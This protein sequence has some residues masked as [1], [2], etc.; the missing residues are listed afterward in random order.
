MSNLNVKEK[1]FFL[2]VETK[3]RQLNRLL[4]ELSTQSEQMK[5]KLDG[6]RS[7]MNTK[8]KR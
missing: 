3:K 1:E 4:E 7:E 5:W 8:R 2:D 6:L